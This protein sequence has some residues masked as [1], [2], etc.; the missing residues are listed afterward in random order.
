LHPTGFRDT[1]PL[2][3]EMGNSGSSSKASSHDNHVDFGALSPQGIYTGQQDWNQAIVAQ[4][5]AE[6]KLAPFYRPLE[7]Y[8]DSW[9]DERIFAATKG[10]GDQAHA[11]DSDSVIS[12]IPLSTQTSHTGSYSK[13]SGKAAVRA[14]PAFKDVQRFSEAQVYRGAVE[15]P[16]CF[17]VRVFPLYWVRILTHD[18]G[19][20]I[21][22]VQY[23]PPNIN[24][25]R[26]C[27]QAI[28]TECFVQIKRADPTTTHVVS[29]PACCPY[30]VQPNFGVTY[31]PP[32]WKAG[33]GADVLVSLSYIASAAAVSDGSALSPASRP[34]PSVPN[35]RQTCPTLTAVEKVGGR[36]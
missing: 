24:Q 7:D 9:D 25:S 11:A 16:I 21:D 14:P 2:F 28:C 18:V 33:I 19:H 35:S 15:C 26:C 22:F 36:V 30:C 27:D 34:L 20:L 8:D 5:I 29:E 31:V 17:L 3:I 23:Y 6:R 32:S 13:A 1:S 4:L 12:H 10:G